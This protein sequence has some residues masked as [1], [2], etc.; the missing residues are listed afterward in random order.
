[1]LIQ[2]SFF[3]VVVPWRSKQQI[4]PR[5]RR[6]GKTGEMLRQYQDHEERPRLAILRSESQVPGHRNGSGWRR[7]IFSFAA[8]SRELSFLFIELSIRCSFQTN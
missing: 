8:R 3:P 1:M 7:S 2:R 6:T 5:V 4:S